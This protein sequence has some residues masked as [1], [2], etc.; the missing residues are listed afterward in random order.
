MLLIFVLIIQNGSGFSATLV[1]DPDPEGEVTG[2][3]VYFGQDSHHYSTEKDVGAFTEYKLTLLNRETKYYLAVKAYNSNSES[4]YSEEISYEVTDG[5]PEQYDN[6]PDM[7]NGPLLGTCVR[8]D[9]GIILSTPRTCMSDSDCS[10]TEECQT[11]QEDIDENNIG[12]VCECHAD[13]DNDGIIGI[14]DSM[15]LKTE[16]GRDDCDVNLCYADM[17]RDYMVD[18]TDMAIM[19]LEYGRACRDVNQQGN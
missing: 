13:L 14:F 11:N 5:I 16:I 3:K 17:N 7:P 2:Y 15:I 10:S 12:D 18:I 9:N 8:E 1:W 19:K 6:C 4:D